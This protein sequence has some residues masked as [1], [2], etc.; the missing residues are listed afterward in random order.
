M[1][2]DPHSRSERLLLEARVE[3]ISESDRVWLDRHLATCESCSL[4]AQSL[5]RALISLRSVSVRVD[6]ALISATRFRLMLRARELHVQHERMWGLWIVGGISWVLGVASAPFVWR[7][8][9]W[10]GHEADLPSLLWQ[11]G[12]VLWWLI[13]AGAV[14]AILAWQRSRLTN[15]ENHNGPEF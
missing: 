10:M 2:E 5:D 1:T 8:F 7:A 15:E 3:G 12:F 11:A 13:P 14:A 4:H 6:P 9:E